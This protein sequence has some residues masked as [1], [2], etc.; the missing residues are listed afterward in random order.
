MT[1]QSNATDHLTLGNQSETKTSLTATQLLERY[2]A[3]ER[4][5]RQVQLKRVDLKGASL[6][7]IDLRGADLSYVNLREADLSSADLRDA[8]LDGADLYKANL[9][10]VN[11]QGARLGKAN[12]KEANLT[13]A[14]LEQAHLEGAFLT[15]A[16]MSRANLK[17]VHLISAHLNEADLR[18]ANLSNAYLDSAYLI[19][20]NIQKAN[21]EEA[22]LIGA[23]LS[24]ASLGG[25]NFHGG[26]YTDKTN[27]DT[28][29]DP[30]GAGLRKVQKTTLE[31]LLS[32][33]KHLSE[34]AIRYI[35]PKMTA[36]YWESSR[37]EFEW[38]RQKFQVGSSG[39]ISFSG[40]TAEPLTFVQ[41]KYGYRWVDNF[42]ESC[43]A[44][45]QEFPNLIDRSKLEFYSSQDNREN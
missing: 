20:A 15:K 38:L 16:L 6:A 31:E 10:R 41:L 23:F 8:C 39:Q 34:S 29:F 44:I 14:S 37:P 7:Q 2:A 36:R 24:G 27:F 22:S 19:Q 42:V 13:R 32:A 25:V 11:L 43:S 26:Y 28:S 5:F 3:G 33:F 9:S 45:V 1:S 40:N 18:Y 30:V 12:L 21:L 35:G 4:K 17:E